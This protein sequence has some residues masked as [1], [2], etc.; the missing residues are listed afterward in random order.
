[1]DKKEILGFEVV[2][3]DYDIEKVRQGFEAYCEMDPYFAVEIEKR[4]PHLIKHF[5][6]IEER[7]QPLRADILIIED[8]IIC[9]IK[10]F[11][12]IELYTQ[13]YK[14]PE[15]K[16]VVA[17]T[18]AESVHSILDNLA[19]PKNINSKPRLIILDFDLQEK[20]DSAKSILKIVNRIEDFNW[21]PEYLAVSGF[22]SRK[23]EFESFEIKLRENH[24]RTYKKERL[25][26]KESMIDD[27]EF[28]LNRRH[29]DY[30]EKDRIDELYKVGND[31]YL[32]L[33]RRFGKKK[34][35]STIK[36]LDGLELGI[37]ASCQKQEKLNPDIHKIINMKGGFYN[38]SK[39]SQ[40][41][42]VRFEIINKLLL[43]SYHTSFLR[44]RWEFLEYQICHHQF[45]KK[46]LRCPDSK[47]FLFNKEK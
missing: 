24:H 26:D 9:I 40:Q 23:G 47:S 39:L 32:K 17:C 41:I 6:N 11:Y 28:L 35:E 13:K 42:R 37:K 44:N 15:I 2:S 21:Y 5:K 31:A 30:K 27:L 29:V 18:K 19:H 33:E 34:I 10:Y 36:F 16:Y 8:D 45:S 4:F 46:Y 14:Y 38:R 1:M 43:L 25:D 20:R 7:K 3:T 22:K 12:F